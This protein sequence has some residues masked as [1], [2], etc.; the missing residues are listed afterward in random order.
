M[1][2]KEVFEQQF[3]GQSVYGMWHKSHNVDHDNH[4]SDKISFDWKQRGAEMRKISIWK[5]WE[6]KKEYLIISNRTE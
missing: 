3:S 1:P 2:G 4:W 5:V 6:W